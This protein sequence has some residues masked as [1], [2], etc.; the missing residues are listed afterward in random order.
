MAETEPTSIVKWLRAYGRCRKM[1]QLKGRGMKTGAT[2][3]IDVTTIE[4]NP[5][6]V[7][8]ITVPFGCIGTIVLE[9]TAGVHIGVYC[10][11][12]E[13]FNPSGFHGMLIRVAKF[14][15]KSKKAVQQNDSR[16]YRAELVINR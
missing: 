16:L 1:I 2:K 14:A 6:I 13:P 15:A 8:N 7:S 5:I 4:H 12:E 9:A 11:C 3:Q 10:G